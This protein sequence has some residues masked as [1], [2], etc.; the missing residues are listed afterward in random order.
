[1]RPTVDCMG[2]K[3]KEEAMCIKQTTAGWLRRY[4]S[5]LCS[6]VL[7]YYMKKML[8]LIKYLRVG[9]VVVICPED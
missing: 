3:T 5:N 2:R 6:C 9:N 1:M 7:D 8:R 4:H